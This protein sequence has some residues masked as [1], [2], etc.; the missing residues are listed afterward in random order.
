MGDLPRNVNFAIR[1]K[2]MRG[3]PENHRVNVAVSRDNTRLANKNARQG[4]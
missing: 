2:V 4:Q 3:F 1:G